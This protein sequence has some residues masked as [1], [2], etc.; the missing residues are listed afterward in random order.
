MV[1]KYNQE[2]LQKSGVVVTAGG[3]GTGEAEVG[4]AREAPQAKEHRRLWKM[5]KAR[6]DFSPRASGMSGHHLDSGLLA[7][8]TLMH[9]CCLKPLN[10]G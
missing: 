10:L 4:I 8:G 3:H 2:G 9:V 5:E 6:E 1:P 7:S